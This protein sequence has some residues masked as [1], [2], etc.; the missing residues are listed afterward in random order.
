MGLFENAHPSLAPVDDSMIQSGGVLVV[1][2]SVSC[3][4]GMIFNT[5]AVRLV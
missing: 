5:T 1:D 2:G 4:M 3:E